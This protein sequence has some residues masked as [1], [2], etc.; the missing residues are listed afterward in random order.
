MARDL[1]VI[2]IAATAVLSMIVDAFSC[3]LRRRL[4][5][6][7]MPTRLS[8]APSETRVGEATMALKT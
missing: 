1:A 8:E 2:L 7:A 6:D 5:I 4:R 3:G